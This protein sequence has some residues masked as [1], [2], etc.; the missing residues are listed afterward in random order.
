[1]WKIKDAYV[2]L[3]MDQMGEAVKPVM[4]DALHSPA[5]ESR[6]YAL[7]ILKGD[8]KLFSGLLTDGS[9]DVN[10]VDAAVAQLLISRQR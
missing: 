7:C 3:L 2:A 1:L 9:V 10:K 5:A 4:A 8:F 6:A